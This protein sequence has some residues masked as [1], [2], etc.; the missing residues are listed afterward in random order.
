M[1][2]I[3]NG[4]TLFTFLLFKGILRNL[5]VDPINEELDI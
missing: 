5:V 4:T 1:Y 2:S 3:I